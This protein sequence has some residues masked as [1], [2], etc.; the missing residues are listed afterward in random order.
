MNKY[1][2]NKIVKT[3]LQNLEFFK[4]RSFRQ[5]RA[6]KMRFYDGTYYV[7]YCIIYNDYYIYGF[8]VGSERHY[9]ISERVKPY[10]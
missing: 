4:S 2:L 5:Q 10:V 3:Q 6:R 9:N 7:K 1:Y 8:K